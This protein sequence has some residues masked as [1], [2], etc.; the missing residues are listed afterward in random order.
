V[1][2]AVPRGSEQFHPGQELERSWSTVF[3]GLPGCF[4]SFRSILFY[5]GQRE[6]PTK[7]AS[8]NTGIGPAPSGRPWPRRGNGR[9]TPTVLPWTA[10]REYHPARRRAPRTPEDG[11]RPL[12]APTGHA[13]LAAMEGGDVGRDTKSSPSLLDCPACVRCAVLSRPWLSRQPDRGWRGTSRRATHGTYLASWPEGHRIRRTP[14]GTAAPNG[15]TNRSSAGPRC[16]RMVGAVVL[17]DPGCRSKHGRS[18]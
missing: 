4:G 7:P 2:V 16:L 9:G 10:R 5:R 6:G 17:A 18:E 1:F 8:A 12:A 15:R 13:G 11:P 14:P 3:P